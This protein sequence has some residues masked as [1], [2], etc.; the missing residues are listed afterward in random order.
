MKRLFIDLDLC[1]R[2]DEECHLKCSYPY[3]PDN[4]GMLSLR[5]WLAFQLICRRCEGAP[6]TEACRYDAL[7]RLEDGLIKRHNFMCVSCKSCAVACPFGTIFFEILPFLTF[8]CDLCQGRL[9]EGEEPVCVRACPRGALKYGDFEPNEAQNQ[10]LIGDV[11][12]QMTP[13]K[14][15]LKEKA[16]S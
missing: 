11:V 16:K 9:K 8:T 13:W 3:H 7:E 10:H 6:C 15:E 1:A 4:N 5:E 12:V 14:K 2:C